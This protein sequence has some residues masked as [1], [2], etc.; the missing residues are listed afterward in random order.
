MLITGQPAWSSGLGNY[1][2]VNANTTGAPVAFNPFN[3]LQ[4]SVIS[5]DP[6]NQIGNIAH[7][8]YDPASQF[9]PGTDSGE[10]HNLHN[11]D[12]GYGSFDPARMNNRH[13]APP[14]VRLDDTNVDRSGT[15][16]PGW[17]G[18]N[19]SSNL[20]NARPN[21][22]NNM[23]TSIANS[24]QGQFR[25]ENPGSKSQLPGSSGFKSVMDVLRRA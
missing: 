11:I 6:M 14:G 20:P 7:S 1:A 5:A 18:N 10:P 19:Q 24:Q 2:A 3:Q 22:L 12:G 13:N 16:M 8:L 9:I 25:T 23:V 4:R 21:A 17:N 15:P